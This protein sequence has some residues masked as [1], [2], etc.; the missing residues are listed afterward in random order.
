MKT[1]PEVVESSHI[2][3]ALNIYHAITAS[4]DRF[5]TARLCVKNERI[6]SIREASFILGKVLPPDSTISHLRTEFEATGILL[7]QGR[8]N[9]HITQ[10]G[11]YAIMQI[12]ALEGLICQQKVDAELSAVSSAIKDAAA[13]QDLEAALAKANRD[14]A[15]LQAVAIYGGITASKSRFYLAQKVETVPMNFS[16]LRQKVTMANSSL[17]TLLSEYKSSGAVAGDSETGFKITEL[18]KRAITGVES[19][20]NRLLAEE[21]N[22]KL[23]IVKEGGAGE[24]TLNAYRMALSQ[25]YGLQN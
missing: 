11:A 22:Q 2:V 20:A 13:L 17:S 16:Q 4:M 23:A 12:E 21:I 5:E 10:T 19:L 24:A 7:K 18:G 14:A 9:H 6:S 25:K 15:T 8:N 1:Q 3:A